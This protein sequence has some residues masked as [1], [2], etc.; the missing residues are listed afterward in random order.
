MK[1]FTRRSYNRKLIVLGISLLAAVGL[2]STGFSAWVMSA[3][4]NADADAS[5]NV[6]IIQ[7]AS[8]VVTVDQWQNETWTPLDGE[9][10]LSFDA[11]KNDGGRLRG[12][13]EEDE[14]LS[15]VISGKVQNG[16]V[17]TAGEASLSMSIALPDGLKNAIEAKY[18]KLVLSEGA[19]YS[20]GVVTVQ[21][22]ALSYEETEEDDGDTYQ[23]NYTLTFGWG[24]FFGNENPAVFYDSATHKRTVTLEGGGTEDLYGKSISDTQ[25]KSEVEAFRNCMVNNEATLTEQYTGTIDITV[26]ATVN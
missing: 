15:M 16:S 9:A 18:I 1:K 25:M 21:M 6:G 13:A 7:D 20:N 14:N 11:P 17:L 8:V 4:T 10:L 2:I 5:V 22:S 12:N 23:F 3:V 19:S 24:A 26:T